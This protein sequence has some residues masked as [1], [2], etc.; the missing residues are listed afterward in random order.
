[1]ICGPMVGGAVGTELIK[2]WAGFKLYPENDNRRARHWF[3][4][5]LVTQDLRGLR[6]LYTQL[7]KGRAHPRLNAFVHVPTRVCRG[8]LGHIG[9]ARRHVTVETVAHEAQHAA[10]YYLT[11]VRRYPGFKC[12]SVKGGFADSMVV[13][14]E[15][16][17][18][19]TGRI[20][21][22][23]LKGLKSTGGLP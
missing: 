14:N 23:L 2:L 9:F 12:R 15:P 17:A 21:E 8:C 1:M 4:Q 19:C 5:V 6:G 22:A 3:Y 7:T 11:M 20:V 18:E 10:L 16:L 13:R